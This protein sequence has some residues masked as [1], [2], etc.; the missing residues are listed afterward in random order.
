MGA[1][2][3]LLVNHLSNV[4]A[5]PLAAVYSAGPDTYVFVRDGE[6]VKARK[7]KIGQTNDTHA[8]VRD[9]LDA[10]ASVLL[11]AAGQGRELLEQNGIKVEGP[12][13]RSADDFGPR[14]GRGNRNGNGAAG[15]NPD[16]ARP[17]GTG[18]G[19]GLNG[20]PSADGNKGDRGQNRQ[21][22][23]PTTAPAAQ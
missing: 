18:P 15:A 16:A 13:T 5:V 23:A 3:E 12:S 8:Q 10:G 7:V 17:D 6:K 19:A 21:P 11:L 9:G 20:P 2:V 1:N 22:Q 14:R 4:L